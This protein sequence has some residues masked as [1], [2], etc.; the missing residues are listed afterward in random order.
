MVVWPAIILN[1]RTSTG[2][3]NPKVVEEKFVG[4]KVPPP[5]KASPDVAIGPKAP[6][7]FALFKMGTRATSPPE[8][9]GLPER[10]LAMLSPAISMDIYNSWPM[11]AANASPLIM[12]VL[13]GA[14]YEMVVPVRETAVPAATAS[15]PAAPYLITLYTRGFSTEVAQFKESVALAEFMGSVSVTAMPKSSAL[16]KEMAGFVASAD[17]VV[18]LRA[19]A[20]VNAVPF[21]AFTPVPT[22]SV[23]VVLAVSAALGANNACLARS[24]YVTVPFTLVDPTDKVIL[25]VVMLDESMLLENATEIIPT[26][27]GTLVS[28]ELGYDPTMAGAPVSVLVPGVNSIV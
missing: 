26:F 2:G 13:L 4:T 24:S 15:K 8:T 17:P 3:A 22:V 9:M 23:Y 20:V 11:A 10:S 6:L 16:M 19:T 5:P 25:L 21:A 7:V 28:L 27:T 12:T 14:S 18:K 1:G